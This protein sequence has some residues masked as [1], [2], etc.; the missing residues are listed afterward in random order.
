MVALQVV[1]K[2]ILEENNLP[3]H[4]YSNSLHSSVSIFLYRPFPFYH[5]IILPFYFISSSSSGN[6][7]PYG[8]FLWH[9]PRQYGY[10]KFKVIFCPSVMGQFSF[11][12]NS[13]PIIVSQMTSTI[14][15]CLEISWFRIAVVADGRHSW[16]FVMK[17]KL[18]SEDW[19]HSLN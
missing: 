3:D 1:P 2:L 10:F 7:L 18:V 11:I 15:P 19:R 4:E 16:S 6:C 12:S 8:V 13:K 14:L 5:F 17:Y 9:Y